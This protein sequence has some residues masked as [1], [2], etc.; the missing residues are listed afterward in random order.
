MLELTHF[1]PLVL[2]YIPENSRKT[3]GFL[4]FLENVEREQLCEMA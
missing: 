4:L 1:K 3:S 2:L